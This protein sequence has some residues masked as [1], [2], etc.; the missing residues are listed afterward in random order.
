MEGSMPSARARRAV[1]QRE[2]RAELPRGCDPRAQP[3]AELPEV[4]S[5]RAAEDGHHLRQPLGIGVVSTLDQTPAAI[6]GRHHHAAVIV[7]A[8]L[9]AEQPA[10]FQRGERRGLDLA[11]ADGLTLQ[12]AAELVELRRT[13]SRLADAP[14]K[15]GAE[16]FGRPAHL[17]EGLERSDLIF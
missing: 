6:R 2:G 9:P 15:L 7:V 1:A 13:E 8:P 4:L 17:D 11:L 10:L 5:L 14:L 3:L 16:I 12:D